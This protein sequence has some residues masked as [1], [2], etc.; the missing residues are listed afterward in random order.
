MLSTSP[1]SRRG[2]QNHEHHFCDNEPG[3]VRQ[4]NHLES[5]ADSHP[6]CN[7]GTITMAAEYR[8]ERAPATHCFLLRDS[9]FFSAHQSERTT[10]RFTA[11]SR[12]D[13]DRR[14]RLHNVPRP[15]PDDQQ[16]D[17]RIAKAIGEDRRASGFVQCRSREGYAGGFAPLRRETAGR[18]RP[19]GFS[20]GTKICVLRSEEH[21][22]ELQSH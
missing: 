6:C 9:A 4:W 5:V 18:A 15:V 14:F 3:T 20:H 11:V 16:S 7:A 22:S 19:L 1:T 12:Q 8:S 10:I 13:L 17:E 2:R 21:T